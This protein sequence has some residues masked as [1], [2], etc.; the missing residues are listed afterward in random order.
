VGAAFAPLRRLFEAKYYFDDVYNAFTRKVV[1]GGSDA[2]L[3]K[4]LDV[5]L[6]DGAV[7]GLAAFW[8]AFAERAR[9][10]QTG[11]VRSYVLLILAGAVA[12]VGYLLWS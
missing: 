6:I 5:G 4:R 2:V 7:N 3:W 8:T 1:V 11:F 12:V 10:A 9:Y